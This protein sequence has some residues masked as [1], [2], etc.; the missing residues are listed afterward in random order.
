MSFSIASMGKAKNVIRAIKEQALNNPSNEQLKSVV[1][2][3][4]NELEQTPSSAWNNGV[5]VEANGHADT[6]SSRYVNIT[7]RQVQITEDS[8]KEDEELAQ[9][10]G[11]I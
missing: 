6:N 10:E 5:L 9:V 7:I 4:T 3:I 2:F 11:G 8:P 1:D